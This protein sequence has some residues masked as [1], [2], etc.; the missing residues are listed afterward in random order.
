VQAPAAKNPVLREPQ[1]AVDQDEFLDHEG[2]R[3]DRP[4]CQELPV[5]GK[6]EVRPEIFRHAIAELA[7]TSGECRV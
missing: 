4:H 6:R 3:L 1:P 5:V 2:D 7:Q